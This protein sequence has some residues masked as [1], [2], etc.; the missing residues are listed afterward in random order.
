[1][2]NKVVRLLLGRDEW[3][4]ITTSPTL[5]DDSWRRFLVVLEL[6]KPGIVYEDENG[7]DC[8]LRCSRIL[9]S[10]SVRR[11]YHLCVRRAAGGA[12]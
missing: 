3:V 10:F 2:T 12:T 11:P 4:N 7:G 5:S 1:M 8:P 9:D 6:Q